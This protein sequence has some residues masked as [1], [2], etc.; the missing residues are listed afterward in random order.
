LA[1]IPC[2]SA[3]T[4]W[5][6]CSQSLCVFHV[7]PLYVNIAAVGICVAITCKSRTNMYVPYLCTYVILH[8]RIGDS[9]CCTYTWVYVQYLWSVRYNSVSFFA[10]IYQLRLIHMKS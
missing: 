9:R 1:T 3:F 2:I 8:T 5:V 4:L 6:S 7:C 10:N